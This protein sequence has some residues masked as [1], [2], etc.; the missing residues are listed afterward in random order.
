MG[1]IYCF[2]V[3]SKNSSTLGGYMFGD[4]TV[5]TALKWA[6]DDLA[7]GCAVPIAIVDGGE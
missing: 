3:S 5:E 4:Y 7:T 1:M 2:D 6:L